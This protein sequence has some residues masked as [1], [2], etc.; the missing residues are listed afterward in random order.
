[1]YG[2]CK[3]RRAAGSHKTEAGN[4]MP[5]LLAWFRRL[6]KGDP[7]SRRTHVA[8][9][10]RR[11]IGCRCQFADLS[12]ARRAFAA[13]SRLGD[14]DIPTLAAKVGIQGLTVRGLIMLCQYCLRTLD[15]LENQDG[16]VTPEALVWLRDDGRKRMDEHRSPARIPQGTEPP[17][18]FVY[19]AGAM[20]ILLKVKGW[21][22]L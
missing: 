9:I 5:R 16:Q 8:P 22:H 4:Y 20:W 13:V 17:E 19:Y 21:E 7:D 18:E 10:I 2:S 6:F 12:E 3:V 14:E 15:M 11:V 1:M